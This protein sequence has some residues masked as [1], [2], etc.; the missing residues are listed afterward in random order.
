MHPP[1]EIACTLL[2]IDDLIGGKDDEVGR[3]NV[4]KKFQEIKTQIE[5][6]KNLISEAVYVENKT[7]R[8]KSHDMALSL[9]QKYEDLIQNKK[10]LFTVQGVRNLKNG[11][12][13]FGRKN[14]MISMPRLDDF[15]QDITE[16]IESCQTNGAKAIPA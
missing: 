3:N 11:L 9:T 16:K 5:Q 15:I 4:E 2:K 6:S 12:N 8:L 7:D 1:S 14:Y 13:G 10:A